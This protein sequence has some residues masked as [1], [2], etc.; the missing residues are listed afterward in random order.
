MKHKR[1]LIRVA[2][3][4]L[5]TILAILWL[6]ELTQRRSRYAADAFMGHLLT[7]VGFDGDRFVPFWNDV[8]GHRLAP[9][10]LV[11][12]STHFAIGEPITLFVDLS[13]T[14]RWANAKDFQNLIA[15]PEDERWKRQSEMVKRD[16]EY[17]KKHYKKHIK[18]DNTHDGIGEE[19]AKPSE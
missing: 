14:V 16:I 11:S 7:R 19:L 13:G 15:L 17:W 3:V 6:K 8:S 1:I 18:P 9:G 2:I 5:I 4:L 10:W 12:Y